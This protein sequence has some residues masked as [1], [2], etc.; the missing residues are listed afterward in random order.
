VEAVSR[1][2]D[3]TRL[4]INEDVYA[5]L[6]RWMDAR[7]RARV[8]KES[9][10]PPPWTDDVV[11]RDW[12]FCNVN[13]CD[14]RETRWIFDDII[15]KHAESPSLWFNLVIARFINWSP[16]L[17]EIG[18][19]D[20]WDRDRFVDSVAR[21]QSRGDKVYT[22]AYMIPA[23]PS[24]VPKHVYLADAVF[25]FLWDRQRE[26]PAAGSDTCAS[27]DV[28]LRRAPLCGDFLR[29]QIITDLRYTRY[30]RGASDWETFILPGPGTQRGLSRLHGL[31]L[32]TAW[33]PEQ[34]SAALRVLRSRIVAEAPQYAETLRDV[35]NL[36]NC[37]CE[38]DKYLRVLRGE[39]KPRASFS[40]EASFAK[41]LA[42]LGYVS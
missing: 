37:M 17:A 23:G 35:N 13:R 24:G 3:L 40:A 36:S 33:S 7:E 39:G 11:I 22:G 5:A 21:R 19:F 27:W 20:V 34:A 32:S 28:F 12:R 42:R 25:S 29:N 16:S 9:G 2:G 14:D 10:A 30:L 18:Y 4:A 1:V 8:L 6:R 15:A 31:P 41:S 26:I 38:L